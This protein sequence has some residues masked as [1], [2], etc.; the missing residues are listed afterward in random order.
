[1]FMREPQQEVEAVQ[2]GTLN[3]SLGL[4]ALAT[5]ALGVLPSGLL[6]L[7]QQAARLLFGTA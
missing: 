3:F 7:V 6:A 1:M 2:Y 5:F 4:T